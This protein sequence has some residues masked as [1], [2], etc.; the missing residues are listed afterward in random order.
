LGRALGPH[1]SGAQAFGA[2][3]RRLDG[4]R[5]PARL[6]PRPRRGGVRRHRMLRRWVLALLVLAGASVST[7]AAS[8]TEPWP[9][10][11]AGPT[12]APVSVGFPSTS[13]FI[14]RDIGSADAA[15]TAAIG[16]FFAPPGTHPAQSVPAVVLLHGTRGMT[17]AGTDYYGCV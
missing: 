8:L 9:D 2:D 12:I 14:P 7:R 4:R 11:D 10:P 13:P 15:P 17:T 5:Q 6:R 1:R 3:D 16:Y